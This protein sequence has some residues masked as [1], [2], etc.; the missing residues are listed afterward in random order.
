VNGFDHPLNGRLADYYRGLVPLVPLV[1]S[2]NHKFRY[3]Q[4]PPAAN[5]WPIT[6]HTGYGPTTHG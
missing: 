6:P 5:R 1:V 2:Y 3:D 4:F